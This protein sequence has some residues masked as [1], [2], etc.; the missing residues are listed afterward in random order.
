MALDTPR[1]IEEHGE[2]AG[3]TSL[4]IDVLDESWV[5]AQPTLSGR[6]G[7]RS[8]PSSTCAASGTPTLDYFVD[9]N[10]P[11]RR[12]QGSLL[13][14][15][16]SALSDPDSNAGYQREPSPASPSLPEGSTHLFTHL[17]QRE[18]IVADENFRA[19]RSRGIRY[20]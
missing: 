4:P 5:K 10:H 8:T 19:R 12:R 15:S 7:A 13:T 3:V 18:R 17:N 6:S 11:C 14:P 2:I 16:I 20:V 9:S 1:A